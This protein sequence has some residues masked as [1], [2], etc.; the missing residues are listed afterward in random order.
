MWP[1]ILLFVYC[2]LIVLASLG[3]GW[4]PSVM[5]LTHRGMQ[6]VMSGV[7]GLMLGVALVHMLPHSVALT[8]SIDLSVGWL[9]AG[10]LL[11]FFLIRAFHFHQ[12]DV[13]RDEAKE[14][15][16]DPG[17]SASPRPPVSASLVRHPSS[18]DHDHNEVAAHRLSWFGVGLGLTLHSLIEGLALAASVQAEAVHTSSGTLLGLGTFLAIL[19]HKPLDALSVTSL[20]LAGG[21]PTGSRQAVNAG[22]AMMCPVGA[23]L[24]ALSLARFSHSGD[25]I[26]GCA[27]GFSA[28]VFLCIS[29][30]DLLPELQFHAHDRFKLSAALL[31]GVLAAYG[32]GLLEPSHGHSPQPPAHEHSRNPHENRA[33]SIEN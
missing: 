10:L 15:R 1:T 2:G 4:L 26:V 25:V 33:L 9:L 21:W 8:E 6:V 18:H 22:F 14:R 7:A 16:A 13:S 24:F 12:H 32:I 19:L 20:M 27:L 29:L 28:G 11:M 23:G 3:G 31:F 17:S 30:G 5:R